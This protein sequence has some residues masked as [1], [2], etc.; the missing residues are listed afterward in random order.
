MDVALEH[1]SIML[2]QA[3]QNALHAIVIS[4]LLLIRMMEHLNVENA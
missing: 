2:I 4:E 3:K 1:V